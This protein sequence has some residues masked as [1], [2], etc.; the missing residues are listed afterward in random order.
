MIESSDSDYEIIERSEITVERDPTDICRSCGASVVGRRFLIAEAS[1]LRA[2]CSETCLREGQA[3][4]RQ[5]RWNTRRRAMKVTVIGLAVAG[6]CLA[7]HQ[8]VFEQRPPKV[9]AAP[10]KA[11]TGLVVP[12]GWFGPEWPP[13]ETSLLA[14]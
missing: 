5:R 2:F 3:A 8:G 7:P 12:N 10:P 14:A 1:G 11:P 9:A 4:V 6:A 13:T